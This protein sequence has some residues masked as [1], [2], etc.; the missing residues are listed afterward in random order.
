MQYEKISDVLTA[1][2]HFTNQHA[3][4]IN[5]YIFTVSELRDYSD[6]QSTYWSKFESLACTYCFFSNKEN[7][8]IYIGMSKGNSGS[9]I[10]HWLFDENKIKK[11]FQKEDIILLISFPE[12]NYMSPALESYLINKFN[13]EFNIKK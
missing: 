9:R 12:Q 4:N 3:I 5:V 8:L 10:Y 7:K 6:K 1:V 2:I 11:K 13:P